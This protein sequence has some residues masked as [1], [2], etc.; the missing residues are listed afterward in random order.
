MKNRRK[1]LLYLGYSVVI[2][3]LL[4]L[5]LLSQATQGSQKFENYYLPLLI[6]IA[7]GIILLLTIVVSYLI[8]I[9]L[10]YRKGLAGASLSITILWRTLLLAFFPMLFISYFA[11]KFL[12]YEF[13]SSF[14]EGINQALNNALVLSKK[15]L[16]V[17]ALNALDDSKA[18]SREL[19]QLDYKSLKRRLESIRQR[20]GAY[21]LTVV[22]ER[23]FIQAFASADLTAVIPPI[24]EYG[25]FV[26]VQQERGIFTLESD[27]T[28]FQIRTLVSIDL[29]ENSPNY[30]LQTVFQ[31]P[32][33]VSELTEQVNRTIS[34]RDRFNYLMPRVNRSFVFVL[35]LVVLLAILLLILASIS[36]ANDMAQPIR[37][38]IQ[39]T[40]RL[41]R[42]DFQGSI[43]VKRN[44]D[45][46]TLMQSFNRMTGSLKA[47]TEEAEHN[48]ERVE[49]E[50][51]YLETIIDHMTSGVM[52]LD[53]EYRLQTYNN[54]AESLLNNDLSQAIYGDLEVLDASLETYS[55]LIKQ[56]LFSYEKGKSSEI[57]VEIASGGDNNVLIANITPLPSTDD[58]HGGYVVIFEVLGEYLQQQKQAAWE[59][60][61]RRL[62]HEIKN[63][64]TPIQLAAERLNYKLSGHLDEK[65]QRVLS[66]SI[67]V[68]TKQ[69]NSLKDMVNDF[70]NFAKP[71]TASKTQLAFSLLLKDVFDLYR[72]HYEGIN[73]HL[74]LDA[75]NDNINA[76]AQVLRQVLHNLAKNA[77]EACEAQRDK[78]PEF[79]GEISFLL[80]SDKTLRLCITDNG[81]GLPDTSQGQ[82]FD[83][84]VTT[85]E[86]GTGLGLA[87]VKKMVQEHQGTIKLSNRQD[88]QGAM[89]VLEFPLVEE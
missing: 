63:P 7:I 49:S 43:V 62:A 71:V 45:F 20:T 73:F 18:I 82:V 61:A 14:D 22:D 31:I 74:Q 79:I 23:G 10:N 37:E 42:G 27:S 68:I 78:H 11:F 19:T 84:Y 57:E 72:G 9:F 85:K 52:T 76:N 21:E 12:N 87:I 44:D 75:S 53:Y 48:R 65:E 88:K 46:G 77:I 36:F 59:E 66:R 64:L 17:R 47:A 56:V 25:D 40:K 32:D 6:T 60:V 16:Q 15:A 51:A 4:S 83:P 50:R 2:L 8:K 39:G 54:R 86:K 30:Y 81:I 35:I 26:R 38:L 33:T 28:H 3:T 13:Q 29:N 89:A 1:I 70:A 67:D 41:S 5:S 34:E 80:T 55:H 58:L 69:V 24:P